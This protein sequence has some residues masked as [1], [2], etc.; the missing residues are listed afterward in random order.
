LTAVFAVLVALAVLGGRL[1]DAWP[2]LPEPVLQ[3]ERPQ[4]G[5]PSSRA[6]E[7]G[8][9]QRPGIPRRVDLPRILEQMRGGQ[10]ATN[11]AAFWE[12]E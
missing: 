2:A 9:A 12:R 5:E 4:V 3:N 8:A 10:L 11:A 6:V 1:R 7:K